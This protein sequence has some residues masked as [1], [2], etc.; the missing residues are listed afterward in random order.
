MVIPSSRLM[1]LVAVRMRSFVHLALF[2]ILALPFAAAMAAPVGYSVNS[3][4][5]LGDTL[6]QI[7][8]ADG[9]STPIGIKI[10]SFG[11]TRTDV[12]GL[13]IATDLSLWGVDEDRL[14]LFQIDTSNGTV[15]Q[16][17]EVSIVGLDAAQF[18]DF[19]LTFSC[20]ETLFATSVTSQSLYVIDLQG[21]AS[22]VGAKG[23]LGVN[24]SAIASSG[25]SPVQ[26]YGLGNGLLGDEGPQDNRSLY[27][28]DIQTGVATAVGDIGPA[29]AD[30]YQAGWHSMHPEHSGPS[31]TGHNLARAARFSVST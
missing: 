1:R 2:S 17:T 8:L 14:S 21:N 26:L 19:G 13:A 9:S 28:I 5:P 31:P 30:Y 29:V 15:V 25:S 20:D 27:K 3:D 7:D 18:N 23:S 16:Q 12:E 24:I 6:H 22:R 10:S 11:V 4:E